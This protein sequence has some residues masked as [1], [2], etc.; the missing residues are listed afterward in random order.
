MV[1]PEAGAVR[2]VTPGA[3]DASKA[4]DVMRPPSQDAVAL[5]ANHGIVPGSLAAEAVPADTAAAV[6][7]TTPVTPV[8]PEPV[9]PEPAATVPEP[10]PA[11]PTTTTY[12]TPPAGAAG[13]QG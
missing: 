8:T 5:L 4:V 9:A 2:Y 11:E 7:T 12:E 1:Q 3:D 13:P 10:T 6:T